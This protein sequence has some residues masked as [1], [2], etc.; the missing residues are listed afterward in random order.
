MTAGLKIALWT[1]I[2]LAPCA[3]NA[4]PRIFP[5]AA[6]TESGKKV[7]IDDIVAEDQSLTELAAMLA[8]QIEQNLEQL[9]T[10]GGLDIRVH[11][12]KERRPQAP[13]DFG[14]DTVRGLLDRDVV[15]EV[16]GR[17]VASTDASGPYNRTEVGYLI[18]PVRYFEF[19]S[20]TPPGA[21]VITHRSE[22]IQSVDDL[23]PLLNHSGRIAAYAALASGSVLL[24][25][26]ALQS[27]RWN[28]AR[29]QLCRA[30]SILRAAASSGTDAELAAYAEK[31]AAQAWTGARADTEYDGFLKTPTAVA[32]C[33]D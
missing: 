16:W 23:V 17:A 7:L 29:T 13:A 6:V 11:A 15:L 33:L 5:C 18:V 3:A 9:R 26:T 24:R 2:L 31:L 12:C 20:G 28:P 10:E 27:A 14:L 4:Q 32:Q 22:P 8:I 19:N 30:V 25:S 1:S 21:F